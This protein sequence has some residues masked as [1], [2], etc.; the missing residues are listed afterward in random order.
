MTKTFK[1]LGN[2]AGFIGSLICL[3]LLIESAALADYQKPS[4]KDDAPKGEETTITGSRGLG[5]C[6]EAAKTSFTALAP[7]GHIGKSFSTHP[8][9]TWH[10]PDA[11]TY[12]LQFRLY[13]YDRNSKNSRGEMI[14]KETLSSTP[15]I[16]SY[17]MPSDSPALESGQKYLWRAILVCNPNSPSQSLVIG[18]GINIVEPSSVIAT[19][20]ERAAT[21][22]ER[23]NIYA[24]AGLW[25]DALTEVTTKPQATE[26]EAYKNQI[27]QQLTAMEHNTVNSRQISPE[28]EE[29]QKRHQQQLT[30][31]AEKYRR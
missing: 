8:T 15:G 19:Q 12:P 20:L 1:N 11:E 29:I 5:S 28:A 16:M 31:I 21:P 17:T 4:T 24:E 7:Y 25:Y 30:E 27:I 3:F 26:F 14:A 22:V 2:S 9:F 18:T 23:A 13:K 6:S 10:I